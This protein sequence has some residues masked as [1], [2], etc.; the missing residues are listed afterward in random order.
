MKTDK[1][2]IDIAAGDSL[3]YAIRMEALDKINDESVYKYLAENAKDDWI[4]LEAAIRGRIR[5]VLRE[6]SVNSD[7]R[8]CLEAAI[9]LDDQERLAD[10]VCTG[11]DEFLKEIAINYIDNKKALKE[12]IEK[13]DS[14]RSRASAAILLGNTSVIRSLITE[15]K[16]ENLKLKLAQFLSDAGIISELSK[17]ARDKRVKYLA[18][19]WL[20]DV[21]PGRDEELD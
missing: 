15:M 8:I 21:P 17:K 11:K 5:K 6:L 4:R 3:S 2:V 10:I 14:E 16:E 9:E 13:C 1:E 18:E 20:E 7:E 12:I 19:E